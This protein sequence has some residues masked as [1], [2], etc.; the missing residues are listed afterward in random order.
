M[1]DKTVIPCYRADTSDWPFK[2]GDLSWGGQVSRFL[3]NLKSGMII[4]DVAAD[5]I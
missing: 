1:A 4:R 5:G 2:K 3:V